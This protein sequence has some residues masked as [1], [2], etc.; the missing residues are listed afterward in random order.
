MKFENSKYNKTLKYYKL[1]KTFG[2]FY[3]CD[4]FFIAELYESIHFDWKMV[5][6]VMSDVCNHYGK[7]AKLGYISNRVDSYSMDPQSWE[8]VHEKY[9]IIQ[10]SAIIAYNNFTFMNATLEKQFSSKSIKRCTSLTE[11][12]DWISN[13]KELN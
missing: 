3:F 4:K 9:G 1:E 12:I 13:S 11:A 7:N 5:E 6:S 8:K 2:N 10:L